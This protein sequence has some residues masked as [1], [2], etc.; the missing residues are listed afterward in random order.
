MD[1]VKR[2]ARFARA[3]SHPVRLQILDLLRDDGAYVTHLV[4]MLERPQAN[5][6]QHLMVLRETG[7]VVAERKGMNVL[8]KASDPLVFEIVD[9]LKRLAAKEEAQLGTAALQGVAS[10]L[11]RK[12]RCR[13]PRCRNR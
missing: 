11:K 13:C 10:M 8:Y 1:L 2:A 5:I 9:G 12:K 6:S 7:L 4:T 3:L